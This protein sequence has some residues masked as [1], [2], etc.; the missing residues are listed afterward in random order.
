[1]E[2]LY[3]KARDHGILFV[4]YE[5]DSR[6]QVTVGDRLSVRLL[7]PVLGREFELA[8]DMLVLATPVVPAQGAEKLASVLKVGVDLNG[9]FMEAHVKLRPVDFPA[10]GMYVAGAAH[11][12]K[13]LDETI[14]QAQA[15]AARAMTVLSRDTLDVGG[16]VARVES[17][18]CVGCLTCVRICPFDVPQ[19][20]VDLIGVGGLAGAAF[21]EP[22][23][24]QGC[25]ICVGE[26][27]AMAIQLLHYR[28]E[29]MEAKIES[30][31]P[32]NE[33]VAGSTV[34]TGHRVA[35]LKS[36]RLKEGE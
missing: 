6:P 23:Q 30:F 18:A 25:G 29:Q 9:W 8:L 22:A 27:P 1:M 21:I 15:A 36:E 26:C 34:V 19:I 32:W 33:T 13:L 12:P 2:R 3:T 4:R 7:D 28:D 16:V 11:Y 10:D 20:R 35:R 24:C 5:W 14:V 17:E 31:F